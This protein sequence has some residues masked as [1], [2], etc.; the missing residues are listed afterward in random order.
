MLKC[1]LGHC[2]SLMETPLYKRFMEKQFTEHNKNYHD[3]LVCTVLGGNHEA[4]KYL[5]DFYINTLELNPGQTETF[6]WKK[7]VQSPRP[8]HNT[9]LM[10]AAER[11]YTSMVEYLL[12]DAVEFLEEGRRNSAIL[13][14]QM[15]SSQ[16]KRDTPLFLACKK[17]KWKSA[18]SLFT[19]GLTHL[20]ESEQSLLIQSMLLETQT[21][22]STGARKEQYLKPRKSEASLLHYMVKNNNLNIVDFLLT[23]VSEGTSERVSYKVREFV[24]NQCDNK[25]ASPLMTAVINENEHMVLLLIANGAKISDNLENDTG[26]FPCTK[27][28]DKSLKDFLLQ[29][30]YDEVKELMD[31]DVATIPKPSNSNSPSD[32]TETLFRKSSGGH[33]TESSRRTVEVDVTHNSLFDSS[34]QNFTSQ[35]GISQA[36]QLLPDMTRPETQQELSDKGESKV[37]KELQFGDHRFNDSIFINDIKINRN[38]KNSQQV[39][40]QVK[41]KQINLLNELGVLFL[42]QKKTFDEKT[43]SKNKEK[44]ANN[45][46]RSLQ[47]SG[48]SAQPPGEDARVSQR[49]AVQAT[50]HHG[51]SGLSS[52]LSVFLELLMER[53]QELRQ[54]QAKESDPTVIF[55]PL[56]VRENFFEEEERPFFGINYDPKAL[57]SSH[58]G[59]ETTQAELQEFLELTQGV[60]SSLDSNSDRQNDARE[61]V[62]RMF[63]VEL[64]KKITR[65]YPILNGREY[66]YTAISPG[67]IP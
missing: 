6:F 17:G 18:K 24:L 57:G 39:D 54:E 42:N 44:L 46:L 13:E 21:K 25:G 62:V 38:L 66:K 26:C 65:F 31:T 16:C 28:H 23:T 59:V 33:L 5:L 64:Q 29:K 32:M 55:E 51:D 67:E 53:L 30:G 22:M 3:L 2:H 20:N 15:P 50:A 10:H 9:L 35:E 4:L 56:D 19:A 49:D 11:G 48:E 60:L 1:L 41:K 14:M 52:L 63:L 40:N 43:K 45:D 34:G 7:I 47:V 12:H 37:K 8:E 36:E 58:T 61:E 27:R